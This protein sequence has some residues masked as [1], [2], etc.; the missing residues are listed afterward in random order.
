MSGS[1]SV[2]QIQ[3]TD[4]GIVVP[5]ESDILDGVKLDTNAAFGNQLSQNLE[6]P[7][8][9]L[10]S[11]WSA[12]IADNNA[13]FA[14]FVALVDPAT[15]SGTMQDA[16][17]KIYYMTRK[18]ALPT[19]VSVL[20]RGG[21][22]TVIPANFLITDVDSNIYYAVDGDTI[23]IDGTVTVPF[24]NT[25]NG[26]IPCSINGVRIYQSLTG[27]D[28]V[29]NAAAGVLGRTVESPQEFE[30]RRSISVLQNN[31]GS[32][33]SIQANVFKVSNVLDVI[34][35][36]NST[37][38]VLY[39]GATNYPL[40]K[41]SIYIGVVGGDNDEI[42]QAIFE[43]KSGTGCNM[44]GGVT[45]SVPDTSYSYP[46]PTYDIKFNRPTDTN[47]KMAVQ[48]KNSPLLPP[49]IV[50]LTKNTVLAA[51]NG[52]NGGKKARIGGTVFASSYYGSIQAISNTV[53]VV[54]V[55]VNKGA[56][57]PIYNSIAFGIDEN[58][59]LDAANISVSLV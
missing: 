29:E 48:I 51:F 44:N 5:L 6:T 40:A 38:A 10:A 1:S 18:P 36:E 11:S 24:A 53:F 54:S 52:E 25:V 27:L 20:C 15:S 26:E 4:S 34:A 41:N 33:G 17:G 49:N 59:T 32:L 7:Q 45:V 47:L 3:F 14:Q 19:S 8:G 57:S 43:K 42:A 12:I 22:G 50:T 35:V 9:Q 30:Y 31:N 2:P 58:P 56:S 46:Q 37:D 39:Y 28:S 13:T 21:V 16:I 23:G 55:L